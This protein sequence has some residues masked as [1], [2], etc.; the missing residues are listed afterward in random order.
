M[1][2]IYAQDLKRKK[3]IEFLSDH[4]IFEML[5]AYGGGG[6][7]GAYSSTSWGLLSI[8]SVNLFSI[9]TLEK[10]KDK[11]PQLHAIPITQRQIGSKASNTDLNQKLRLLEY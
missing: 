6:G 11:L 7:L 2:L 3:C 1:P 4:L 10:L 9:Y 5:F 8:G